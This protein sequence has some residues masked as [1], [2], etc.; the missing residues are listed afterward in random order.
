MALRFRRIVKRATPEARVSRYFPGVR[1]DPS[2]VRLALAEAAHGRVGSL[3]DRLVLLCYHF[4]PV[5]GK[6]TLQVLTLLRAAIAHCETVG[7][8]VSRKLFTDILDSEE[9]HID[10]LETQLALMARIG[11]PNYLLAKIER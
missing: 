9:E 3:V 10:W 8:S 5:T 4:D 2:D 6:Y 7:D 11:E 1:F